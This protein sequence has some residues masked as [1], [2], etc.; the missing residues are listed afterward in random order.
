MG[1]QV[2]VRGLDDDVRFEHDLL[3]NNSKTYTTIS[4]GSWSETQ[5]KIL[6]VPFLKAEIEDAKVIM[7]STTI[8][9][10][11]GMVYLISSIKVLDYFVITDE[12]IDRIATM[13]IKSKRSLEFMFDF[14]PEDC[15]LVNQ[16]FDVINRRINYDAQLAWNLPK[17]IPHHQL[18]VRWLFSYFKQRKTSADRNAAYHNQ[19]HDR[20][21]PHTG[22]RQKIL[23]YDVITNN[24]LNLMHKIVPEDEIPQLC[25]DLDYAMRDA[26]QLVEKY[27]K[28]YN[29]D[30]YLKVR[31][32]N[33]KDVEIDYEGGILM[34]RM[35]SSGVE[36]ATSSFE[37][38]SSTTLWLHNSE[39][40][41]IEEIELTQDLHL[42]IDDP[43][44]FYIS[45]PK[46]HYVEYVSKMVML[47]LSEMN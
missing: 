18:Y 34:I 8:D 28:Y 46:Q 45:I 23:N 20:N 3:L 33:T 1:E 41:I 10:N 7:E 44:V 36:L 5:S 4:E 39:Q 9:L 32:E 15:E 30:L 38:R 42:V 37:T 24:Q 47:R 31:N 27:Q 35:R 22:G 25:R 17:I 40:D 13:I 2:I 6:E 26:G 43:E 12:C 11:S 16:I 19:A 14:N 21:N 29:Y